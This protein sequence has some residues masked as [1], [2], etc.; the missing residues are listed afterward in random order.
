MG[1]AFNERVHIYD[2]SFG[3]STWAENYSST[4]I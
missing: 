1:Q 3:W 4:E 2:T